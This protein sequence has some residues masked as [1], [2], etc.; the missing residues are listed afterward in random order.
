[1]LERLAGPSEVAK[2][3]GLS[4]Q[5]LD[6]LQLRGL[7]GQV[8]AASGVPRPEGRGFPFGGMHIDFSVLDDPPFQ[9]VVLPQAQM[10]ALFAELA[11]EL[12]AELRR[13]HRVTGVAQ[14]EESVTAEVDTPDGPQRLTARFL[15]GC[16]GA[17][18]RVREL[19]GFAFP[20][21][22]YPEVQRL[23]GFTIP[24]GVTLLEN[25]DIEVAGHGRVPFGFTA[26]ERGVFAVGSAFPGTLGIFT[27][28]D[29]ETSYDDAQPMTVAEF[30][31]SVHRVMGLDLPVDESDATRLT[32]FTFHARQADSYRRGRVVL[33]GDAAH[34]FP[35]PGCAL[36]AAL[37]DSV[38]LAWKL[39]AEVNG[40]APEELLDSYGVERRIAADRTMM[41]AQAQVTLRRGHDAAADALRALF[42]EL[43]QDE[44]PLERLGR[45]MAA[46]DIRYPMPGDQVHVL[47]GSFVPRLPLVETE[48]LR[49]ARP[50]LLDL[51]DRGEL[52]EVATPWR[53]RV[54]VVTATTP[55]RPADVLLVRPDG[56]VAWA[57]ARDEPADSAA[58]ALGRSLSHWFGAPA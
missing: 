17:S 16:D 28:E 18:S 6:L 37:L 57:A 31:Q 30:R 41:H 20:G 19:A 11:L 23:A 51:A 46:K 36:T 13:G 12:G 21:T 29:E 56:H 8:E 14:D 45:L 5:I 24:D 53:G 47:A 55:D 54:D 26:T 2:A 49:H 32:R 25:G 42:E 40:W 1:V 52:R 15:V 22:T 27:S 33:A 58:A 3:G 10:E 50:V 35:A 9:A 7:L 43:L 44:Q 34:L 38:N 48:L 4:G 39:A